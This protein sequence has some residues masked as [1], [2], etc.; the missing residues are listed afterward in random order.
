MQLGLRHL[1]LNWP[2][3][4]LLFKDIDIFFNGK[5]TLTIYVLRN[6]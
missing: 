6:L 1:I 5:V 4:S 3:E 2:I